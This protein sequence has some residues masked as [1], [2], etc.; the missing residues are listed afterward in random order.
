MNSRS[1]AALTLSVVLGA[2]LLTSACGS[3]SEGSADTPAS[4]PAAEAAQESPADG[5][6]AT[7]S[8][9]A[10][11]GDAPEQDTDSSDDAAA[12][13]PGYGQGCGTNDLDWSA[14]E[15]TQAGGYVLV[16]VKAKSGITC[17]L[18]GGLPV[19][20]FGSGGTQAGPA[21][22]SAGDEITLTGGTKVYA[23][24]AP[25]TTNS[26]AGTEYGTVIVSVS[27]DDPHPVSLKIGAVLVDEPVVTNWHTDPADA[28]PLT[29]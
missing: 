9:D 20:A 21:E 3:G 13:K 19:M 22:Q 17:V 25:K 16:S 1:H 14:K 5:G 12:D 11:S 24:V 10:A 8:G 4:S 2:A 29:Q 15:E 28:V 6:D 26:D 23:G 18:P 7:A 27:E